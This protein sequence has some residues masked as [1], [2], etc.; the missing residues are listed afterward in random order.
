MTRSLSL[1]NFS[2]V[3]TSQTSC[4]FS[5]LY[6]ANLKSKLKIEKIKKNKKKHVYSIIADFNFLLTNYSIRNIP[7]KLLNCFNLKCQ[8]QFRLLP[9]QL[10][11]LGSL[12]C[13]PVVSSSKSI[14]PIKRTIP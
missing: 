4:S 8:F 12:H 7:C 6:F 5:K 11:R 13:F 3:F 14:L 1:R 9:L 10:P 2:L